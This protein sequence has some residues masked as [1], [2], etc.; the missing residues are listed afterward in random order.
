MKER[1]AGRLFRSRIGGM[2][3]EAF[4]GRGHDHYQ[5]A[6]YPPPPTYKN[7]TLFLY[8]VTKVPPLNSYKKNLLYY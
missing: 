2:G 3:T 1:Q 6:N 5:G 4:S 8:S 7:Y